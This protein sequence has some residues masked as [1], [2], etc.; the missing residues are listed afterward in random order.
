MKILR[1]GPTKITKATIDAA[2]QR[3]APGQRIVI[4]DASAGDWPW[5]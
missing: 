5:W 2:W 3:R 4:G 1:E